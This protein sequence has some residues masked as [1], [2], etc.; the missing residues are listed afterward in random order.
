MSRLSAL[1]GLHEAGRLVD[2]AQEHHALLDSL[3]AGDAAGAETLMRH[4]LG[5]V[6]GVWAGRAEG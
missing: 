4:H 2:T 6:R 5:H 1:R 3:E